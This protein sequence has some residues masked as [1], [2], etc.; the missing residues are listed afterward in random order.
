MN[1]VVDVIII[2]GGIA[3]LYAAYQRI[4]IARGFHPS[5]PT[6]GEGDGRRR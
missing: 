5:S 4:Q 3:G 2:G 1:N 6:S